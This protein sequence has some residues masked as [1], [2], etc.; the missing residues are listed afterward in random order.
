M[1]PTRDAWWAAES[2]EG[3]TQWMLAYFV[4]Q[5]GLFEVAPQRE[6]TA[7]PTCG[8]TGLERHGLVGG[9]FLEVLCT[10]CH[11]ACFD[12]AVKFR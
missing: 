9:R 1:P 12:E 11:G 4:E 3:R 7:C 10:R 5:S 6:K 2:V 8:G